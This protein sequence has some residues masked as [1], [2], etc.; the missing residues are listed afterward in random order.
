VACSFGPSFVHAQTRAGRFDA[1]DLVAWADGA[2]LLF[3]DSSGLHLRRLDRDGRAH[4]RVGP[5]SAENRSTRL[6]ADDCRGGVAATEHRGSLYV[7]CSSPSDPDRGRAGEV[8]LTRVEGQRVQIVDRASGVGPESRGVAVASDGSRLLVGWQDADGLTSRARVAELSGARLAEAHAIS[9]ESMLASPPSLMLR[10]GAL[11]TAWSEA[12]LE[13]SGRAA[14]HL[15]VQREGRPPVPSLE[16]HEMLASVRIGGDAEGAFIALRDR[17]P[18]T[19]EHERAIVGRLDGRLR[20]LPTAL[21]SPAKADD[22]E[23]RP[24][25]VPCGDYVFSLT[26]RRSRRQVTMVSMRRLSRSL[27]PLEDEH[28]IYEYH[29]RFPLAAAACVEGQLLVALGEQRSVVTPEPRVRTYA[30]RCAPGIEHERTP[31]GEGHA[32]GERGSAR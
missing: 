23:S 4:E 24:A 8:L 22:P 31:G 26:T 21:E 2:A 32:S 10:G 15:F 1:L 6:L 19:A 14:G 30:L 27:R 18:R 29:A 25:L 11:W 3:G 17:R 5:A 9:S 12:W 16:L 13:P 28:Q 20:L 7:A